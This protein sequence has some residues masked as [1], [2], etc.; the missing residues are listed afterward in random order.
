MMAVRDQ[1]E[2]ALKHHENEAHGDLWDY[3]GVLRQDYDLKCK[4]PACEHGEDDE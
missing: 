2:A 4:G 3:A 1:M